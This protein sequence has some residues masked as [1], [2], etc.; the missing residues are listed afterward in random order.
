MEIQV[1]ANTPIAWQ[2]LQTY[3][4][5]VYQ[6]FS[7]RADVQMELIDTLSSNLTAESVVELSENAQ[8]RH[9][10]SSITDA[11]DAAFQASSIECGKS[12]RQAQNRAIMQLSAAYAPGLAKRNFWLF[13]AD[14]SGISRKFAPTLADRTYVYSP[15]PV[16]GNKPVTIG[17]AY[18]ATV[19]LLERARASEPCWVYPCLIE[20]I[21]SDE[22]EQ[23]VAAESLRYLH[24][25]PSLPWHGQLCVQVADSKYSQLDYIG[26][27][28]GLANVVTVT[29]LRSNQVFYWP[30]IPPLT[31]A[32]E[33]KKPGNKKRYGEK[34]KLKD[35]ASWGEAH[36]SLLLPYRSSQGR[37]YTVQIQR[38]HD[39]LETG[40]R[41]LAMY[42]HPFDLLHIRLLD[43]QQ[44]P[45]FKK[46]LWLKLHGAR[47]RE[48][49]TQDGYTA[50]LQRMDI[51]QFWRFGKQRLLLASYQTPD[52][53]HEESWL[54]LVQLAYTQLYL[55]RPLLAACPRPWERYLP[56]ASYPSPSPTH[57]LRQAPS[58]FSQIGTPA[59]PPKPRGIAKGRAQGFHPPP[60]P[61][62][63]IVKKVQK[64]PEMLASP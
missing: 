25:E 41:K 29:R 56:S 5:E 10:Y 21:A 6:H 63:P 40:R 9:G 15:Y 14:G 43:E 12:E 54:H 37:L 48:L 31:P 2:R 64:Q 47:R 42:Q 44:Q 3:R 20:R 38:W 52:V 35:A 24:D 22:S 8:F 46:P 50:Y 28:V 59:Q 30:A 45:L 4:Q 62:L 26:V 1:T 23:Q 61:R 58:I 53:E 49:S 11:I 17:H 19:L 51:E 7:K 34:F 55:M 27:T 16:A 32:N 13:A 39:L 57:V 18:H 36:E 33:K 60:R